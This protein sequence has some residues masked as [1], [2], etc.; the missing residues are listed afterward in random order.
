V[1]QYQP[2]PQQQQHQQQQQPCETK[3]DNYN[4]PGGSAVGETAKYD[5]SQVHPQPFPD[6]AASIQPSPSFNADAAAE[7][8]CEK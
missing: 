7:V 5:P 3:S 2:P 1:V 6:S 8:L 4:N